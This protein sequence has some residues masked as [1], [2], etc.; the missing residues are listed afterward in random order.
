MTFNIG[1]IGLG[2]MGAGLARNMESK[3]ISVATCDPDPARIAG[4]QQLDHLLNLLDTPRRI[5]IM[6]PAG[7]AVDG[8]I[9]QLSPGLSRGD[10]L[11]DGG[12]SHFADTDRRGNDLE[13][14]GVHFIGAGISGGEAGA[15]L[16]PAIM[17]GGPRDAWEA[18]APLLRAIAA[19]ADDGEPCVEYMGV[20]GAGHYVKMVHNGIEYGDMQQIAE[21]YDLLHRGAGLSAGELGLLFRE[22]NRS[23]LRSYLIEITAQIFE[24]IDDETGRP[25]IDLVV[26]EAQQKGTGKWMSKDGFD[27]G[28]PTPTVN[29]AVEA[30]MLSAMKAE[31][32]T[33]SRVLSGPSNAFSGSRERLIDA[34]RQALY[35]SKV[36]LHAQGFALLRSGS[37]EYGYGIDPALVARVWRAGCI[38]RASLLADV[39]D[40]YRR[41]PALLNLLMDGALAEAIASR[42]EAWRYMVQT[43]VGLGIP[44]PAMCASL[45][46]YDAYRSER[47]PANL[48]QAQRDFFGAHRY[49]RIDRE[50]TFHTDWSTGP[51]DTKRAR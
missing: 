47:L 46:Y 22:W 42:H 34:A 44:V 38:I 49:R 21:T 26:D 13:R 9:A 11:I 20:R 33:A 39:H 4:V 12:N 14:A 19:K 10:I 48:L 30:R 2:V 31:R 8:V 16:G 28:V 50:G 18:L 32:V 6:V 23:E 7:S 40:A 37:H 43:A 5:L 3:G 25:L 1:V 41:T 36:A 17:P 15:L 51:A 45:A 29:S 27:V 35:A 24:R